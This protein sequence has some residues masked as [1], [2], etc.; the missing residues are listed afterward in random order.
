MQ[1][2]GLFIPLDADL[3]LTQQEHRA[4][5]AA[6]SFAVVYGHIAPQARR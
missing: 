5:E 6:L 3:S 2:P 4:Q 1:Q